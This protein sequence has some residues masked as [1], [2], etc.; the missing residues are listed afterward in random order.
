MAVLLS[1]VVIGWVGNWMG[2]AGPAPVSSV[3][4]MGRAALAL[5][6]AALGWAIGGTSGAIAMALPLLVWVALR[7]IS[8]LISLSNPVLAARASVGGS[9]QAQALWVA[10]IALA[11]AIGSLLS[12]QLAERVGWMALPWQ[13]V[14]F[15]TLA[16]LVLRFGVAPRLKGGSNEPEPEM[17]LA[18]TEMEE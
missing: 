12:G 11:G 8:P 16:F 10:A 7:Q 9:A 18:A 14:I 4:I 13:T 2:K 3:G 5:A 1:L 17:L 6:L 15:C